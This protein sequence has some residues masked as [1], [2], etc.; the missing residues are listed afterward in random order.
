MFAKSVGVFVV[1]VL[2]STGLGCAASSE[3][4]ERDVETTATVQA[5]MSPRDDRPAPP[6]FDPS[7]PSWLDPTSDIP[8]W[9]LKRYFEEEERGFG[10][11]SHCYQYMEK[12]FDPVRG[13]D[14]EVPITVCN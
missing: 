13:R 5:A 12:I 2:M 3:E 8:R 10:K 1:T 4:D 9:D 14:I 6:R 11:M 7:V